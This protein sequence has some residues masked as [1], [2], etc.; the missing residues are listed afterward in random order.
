MKKTL[1][2]VLMIAMFATLSASAFADTFV[3]G[4]F[5]KPAGYE[6]K[7]DADTVACLVH[8]DNESVNDNVFAYFDKLEDA[9]NNLAYVQQH[10]FI[11]LYKSDNSILK[12]PLFELG[13]DF[14][15]IIEK[16][17]DVEFTGEVIAQDYF[18]V[19]AIEDC[20]EEIE[21]DPEVY[22]VTHYIVVAYAPPADDKAPEAEVEAVP[23]DPADP[24]P[25]P[26]PATKP[27]YT[28]EIK[29]DKNFLLFPGKNVTIRWMLPTGPNEDGSYDMPGLQV[30]VNKYG[31]DTNVV[32]GNPEVANEKPIDG[33]NQNFQDGNTNVGISAGTSQVPVE[34]QP[35][36]VAVNV[37]GQVQD[38]NVLVGGGESIVDVNT[39]DPA[40]S[41][42]VVVGG[43]PLVPVYVR[44]NDTTAEMILG[45]LGALLENFLG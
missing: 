36:E 32:I 34:Q 21:L 45:I 9:F 1:A 16:N 18:V 33:V 31:K 17:S 26:A 19:A 41:T 11:Y 38:T 30:N 14:Y 28:G 6:T 27:A 8:A 37:D 7:N 39:D 23:E 4:Y 24:T 2:I 10:D 20:A 13:Q 35:S 22:D 43:D 42:D 12:F 44:N 29:V 5:N 15:M 25:D 40:G 3:E